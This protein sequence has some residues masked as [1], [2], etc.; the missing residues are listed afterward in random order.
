[1]LKVAGAAL[2]RR[3]RNMIIVAPTKKASA[4][5][6]RETMSASSSLHQLLH[7]YGWRW[8]TNAAGATMWTRLSIGETDPALGRRC[9]T[10]PE[11]ASTLAIASS[12]TRPA[13]STSRP[14]RTSRCRRTQPARASPSS[15]TSDKPCP[16]GTRARW[17]SSG[18]ARL[19]RSSSRLLTASRIPTWADLTLAAPRPAKRGRN[20]RGRR[21]ADPNGPCRADQ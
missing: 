19:D 12:S 7:D 18:V 17:R 2:R 13:C 4:V 11:S 6:G 10:A 15:A 16:S 8:T 5:A 21:R 1:M 9:T 20:A 3:G 14:H